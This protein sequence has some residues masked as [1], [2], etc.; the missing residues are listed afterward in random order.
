[1]VNE[2]VVGLDGSGLPIKGGEVDRSC[3][4]KA[5]PR[6]LDSRFEIALL[7]GKR[8]YGKHRSVAAH[9]SRRE[10]ERALAASNRGQGSNGA[11]ARV[12]Y[13]GCL[14]GRWAIHPSRSRV[15]SDGPGRPGV[16]SGHP[17]PRVRRR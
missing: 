1:M 2:I 16:G 11:N 7:T 8:E 5:K 3:G 15:S 10:A 4:K 6:A 17:H 9:G 14:P 12:R 13:Q